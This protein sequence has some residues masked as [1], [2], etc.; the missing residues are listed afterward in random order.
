MFDKNEKLS[1]M[2]LKHAILLITYTI[3]LI[4]V[5]LHMHEV[6]HVVSM[7][8]GMLKPFIY[9]IMMAFIFNLPLKFFMK[10]L[11]DSLK[12]L[13]KTISCALFHRISFWFV[14]FYH[15]NCCTGT[16]GKCCQSSYDASR[17]F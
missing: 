9:G 15:I 12:K 17:I 11:P 8:I 2:T 1:R 4:W 6:L 7:V 10:K 3:A 5:I 14:D 16:C 13:E